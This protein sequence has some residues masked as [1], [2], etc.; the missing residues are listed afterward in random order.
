[1]ASS[2]WNARPVPLWLNRPGEVEAAFRDES[3]ALPRNAGGVAG[4]AESPFIIEAFGFEIA[5]EIAEQWAGLVSRALE[6]NVFMEPGFA[7]A[8]AQHLARA[9]RP[10]FVAVWERTSASERGRLLALWALV[11]R[12]NF[13]GA[14][15]ATLWCHKQSALG[16]PLLDAAHATETVAAVFAWLADAFPRLR[17][18]VFPKLV[19][20]GPTFACI[21]AHALDTGLEWRLLDQHKRAALFANG[22][23]VTL[24]KEGCQNLRRRRRQLE[25]HGSVRVRSSQSPA[26]IRSATEDFLALEEKG[27]KGKRRTALLCDSSRAAFARTITRRLAREGKCRIDALTIDDR[28]IAMSIMLRSRDR[29]FFWK[30]AYDEAFAAQSPGV[31]LALEATRIQQTDATTRV[32]DSCTA[33]GN[34]MIDRLWADRLPIVDLALPLDAAANEMLGGFAWRQVLRRGLLKWAGNRLR[35]T[36]RKVES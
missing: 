31:Q 28:P 11:L 18:I 29:A 20:S 27:W 24:S 22:A 15:I 19:R 25:R 34:Q 17:I 9:D 12:R 6:P 4:S 26:D 32:T 3:R 23:G 35:R 10:T 16:L 30:I 7:L 2:F 33:P 36:R 14:H 13:L 5:A 21:V 8:A 1:M